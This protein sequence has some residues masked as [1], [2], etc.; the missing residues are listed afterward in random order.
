M[1]PF[2][3]TAFDNFMM[4]ATKLLVPFW[5]PL[6]VASLIAIVGK[7]LLKVL[8][9][10]EG[11]KNLLMNVAGHVR[12]IAILLVLFFF[13]VLFWSLNYASRQAAAMYDQKAIDKA[14][15]P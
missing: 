11:P 5:F 8:P 7:A 3:P 13:G 10:P 9:V 14:L 12:T 6:V 15:A 2:Q 4:G 1:E